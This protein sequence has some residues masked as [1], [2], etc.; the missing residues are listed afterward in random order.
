MN[1]KRIFARE[2]LYLLIFICIGAVA[3]PPALSVIASVVWPN[4]KFTDAKDFAWWNKYSQDELE[5]YQNA[6]LNDDIKEII[7]IWN[8]EVEQHINFLNKPLSERN[9]RRMKYFDEVIRKKSILIREIE[10]DEKIFF[11][12]VMANDIIWMKRNE[13]WI[14]PAT[15]ESLYQSRARWEKMWISTEPEILRTNPIKNFSYSFVKKYKAQ[16]STIFK[17]L[18]DS[19]FQVLIFLLIPYFIFQLIRSIRWAVRQTK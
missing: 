17:G 9:R 7:Q 5:G 16:Y 19:P 13:K 12:M 8:N 3:L 18:E 6:Y 15:S 4:N 14:E 2:W 10:R 1:Y 11:K